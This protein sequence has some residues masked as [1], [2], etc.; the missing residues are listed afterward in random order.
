M[1][2]LTL[3]IKN[4]LGAIFN[5]ATEETLATRGSEATLATRGSE[6]TLATRATEATQL[7]VKAKTDNLDITLSALRDALK[8]GKTLSD[9]WTSLQTQ[10]E[11]STSLWTDDSGAK[12]VRRDIIDESTGTATISWTDESGNAATPGAGLRPL[13]ALD[14]EVVESLFTATSNG[15]GYSSG[16]IIARVLLVDTSTTP[17]T[18]TATW[19]NVTTGAIISAPNA[20]HID[21]YVG[22]TD[23]ELAVRLGDIADAEATGNGTV[24][25]IA[26]RLRTLLSG[27]LPT[28]LKSDRLQVDAHVFARYK[29]AD[30]AA[31]ATAYYGFLANNG[32]WYIMREVALTGEYRYANLSNNATI[33][34][35]Y[36][37]AGADK[38][39]ANRAT[40]TYGYLSALTGL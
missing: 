20:G 40:L 23:Q 36:S 12:Y 4:V 18:L 30:E 6:A 34:G 10:R 29:I 21:Q 15:T 27:G 8:G 11:I 32:D 5:P 25:A 31:G 7:L 17:V 33:T 26:K 1:A 19:M 24:I 14:K 35:G 39:W 28:A 3:K 13:V 38:A 37:G 9:I 2:S 22:L 16:D